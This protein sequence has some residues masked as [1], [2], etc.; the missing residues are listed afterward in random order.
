MTRKFIHAWRESKPTSL[1]TVSRNMHKVSPAGKRLA[2][3]LNNMS[4][5]WN[6]LLKALQKQRNFCAPP[7]IRKGLKVRIFSTL[8]SSVKERDM[9]KFS[10]LSSTRPEKCRRLK[11]CSEHLSTVSVRLP[12]T[13]IVT[14]RRIL[15]C[16][17]AQSLARP[18]VASATT[19][20]D[21]SKVKGSTTAGAE[22]SSSPWTWLRNF[23][24]KGIAGWYTAI[25]ARVQLSIVGT[26]CTFLTGATTITNHMLSSLKLTTVQVET[27]WNAAKELTA[28]F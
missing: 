4:K 18:S 11:C 17:S 19:P 12:S 10:K 23:C 20:G 21:Q 24:H 5:K 8:I 14:T 26:I 15:C 28:C 22:P 25:M 6:K 16:S 7:F 27:N 2:T 13:T 3:S 1:A 9:Q